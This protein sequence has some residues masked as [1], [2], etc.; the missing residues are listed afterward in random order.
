MTVEELDIIVTAKVEGATKEIKKLVPSIKQSMRQVQE[1]FST[2]DVK[3]MQTKF[4]QTIKSIKK[5]MQELPESQKNNQLGLIQ[6]PLMDNVLANIGN[7]KE[8]EE[9]IVNNLSD[10]FNHLTGAMNEVVQ[11]QGFQSWLQWSSDKLREISEKIASIDWQPFMN[12]LMKIGTTIGGI[13]LEILNGLVDF[14]KWI[15]ENQTVAEI[16]LG[17]AVAIGIISTVL[18]IISSVMMILQGVASLLV[19]PILG[20]IVAIAAVIAIIVL[21]IT[22]WDEIC[23]VVSSVVN[24]IIGF[25]QGLWN[26]VSFIF[27]AIWMVISTVLALI[28][29]IF[30][31]V[32]RAI[33]EIVSPILNA[34]WE[35]ISIIFQAVWNIVSSILGS[36]WNIFSQVFNAIWELT[37]KIFQG[38]WNIISPMMNVIG[39]GIKSVL[40]GIQLAWCTIWNTIANVVRNV[41]NGIWNCIKGIINTILGGIEGFINSII[42]GINFLLGGISNVANAVGSFIG[43]SPINLRINTIS[44]PRL[45]KGGVLTKATAIIAGEYSGA[46]TNPEIV[47]PQN[48]MEET[49][50]RVI[51]RYQSKDNREVDGLKKLEIH[52]G[53]SKVAYE[54]ADLLNQ[55]KRKAGRAIVEM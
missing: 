32:F 41:W 36:I 9:A 35:I 11:S 6:I 29:N 25:L 19:L 52:F 17:I 1:A 55:A 18:G 15:V 28:E 38:I 2:I 54:I 12:A 34:I 47:T 10:A 43:L 51:S 39:N 7:N 4:Q 49:F 31:T 23:Q 42:R 20:I 40:L 26:N 53:S 14:F 48:I 44:L 45:A 13:A 33:W 46:K 24:A 37:T 22:Y 3:S 30:G 27:E 50:A 5:S 8:N 16:L 21:C